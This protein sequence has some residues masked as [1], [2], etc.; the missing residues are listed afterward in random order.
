MLPSLPFILF[1]FFLASPATR[2]A[3]ATPTSRGAHQKLGDGEMKHAALF[4]GALLM[5]VCCAGVVAMEVEETWMGE[6]DGF[7]HIIAE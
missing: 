6:W 1:F 2:A 7:T 4:G 5:C 3:H